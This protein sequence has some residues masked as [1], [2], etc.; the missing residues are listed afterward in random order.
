MKF[1][2]THM[3]IIG[4]VALLVGSAGLAGFV[5]SRVGFRNPEGFAFTRV[6]GGSEGFRG[7]RSCLVAVVVAISPHPLRPALAL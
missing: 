7:A 2:V 4:L 5:F 6:G 1:T 3:F